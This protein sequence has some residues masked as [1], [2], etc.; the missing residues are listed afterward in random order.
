M[1]NIIRGINELK[2]LA[3]HISCKCKCRFDG[4]KCNSDQWWNNDKCQYECKKC[5]ACEKDYVWNPET[6]NS[7]NGKDLASIMDDSALNHQQVGQWSKTLMKRKQPV[8][9]KISTFYL[10]SLLITIA[11]LI[12]VSTYYYLIKYRAK[13]LLPFYYTNNQLREILY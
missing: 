4:K 3:K 5:H 9:R 6:S 13:Q 1:F 11:L 7:E 2:P 12:A 8:K 10:I